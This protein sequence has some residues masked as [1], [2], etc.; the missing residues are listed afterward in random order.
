MEIPVIGLDSPHIGL[1]IARRGKG[2][3]NAYPLRPIVDIGQHDR[4]IRPLGYVI[5]TLLPVGVGPAGS[6]G[7]NRNGKAVVRVEYPTS[8]ATISVR[9]RATRPPRP[10][11]ATALPAAGRTTP[12]SS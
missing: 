9:R 11:N 12:S 1:D 4:N 7:C 6:L 10:S 3:L 2:T 5:E 8:C